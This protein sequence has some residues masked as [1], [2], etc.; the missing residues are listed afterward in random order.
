MESAIEKDAISLR[1][2]ARAMSVSV[3][4]LSRQIA[5]GQ[6]PATLRIGRRRLIRPAAL[7]SWLQKMEGL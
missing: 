7:A 2:A 5:V 3:R 6:G 4:T 1:E